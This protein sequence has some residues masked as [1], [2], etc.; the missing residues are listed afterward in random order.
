ML[1]LLLLPAAIVNAKE[2][3]VASC[4]A[5]HAA[6]PQA[7]IACLERALGGSKAAAAAP[8]AAAPA[9]PVE[10]GAEQVR[11]RKAVDEEP[12]KV[13]VRIVSTTYGPDGRGTF[14]MADGQVWR[15]TE[16]TPERQRLKVDHEYAAHIERGS[17]GGY[18][19]YVDGVRRMIK[20]QRLQ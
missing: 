5:Q 15:E 1:C 14:R 2:D 6:D 3:P 20:L 18:R 4:R 10:L 12:E 13:A 9:P 8:A 11:A 19:M 17:F 7:H 16:K